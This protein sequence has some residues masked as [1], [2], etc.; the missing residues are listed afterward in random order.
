MSFSGGG[1]KIGRAF[2]ASM[3]LTSLAAAQGLRI[4]STSIGTM[5]SGPYLNQPSL[6]IVVSGQ[7]SLANGVYPYSLS[8]RIVWNDAP[9]SPLYYSVNAFISFAQGRDEL[10]QIPLR[11]I[12][13]PNG[14]FPANSR[15]TLTMTIQ[16]KSAVSWFT[17]NPALNVRVVS[18]PPD[19]VPTSKRLRKDY[20]I[21]QPSTQSYNFLIQVTDPV[22]GEGVANKIVKFQISR[23]MADSGH[24]SHSLPLNSWLHELTGARAD[25]SGLSLES[26]TVIGQYDKGGSS[27]ASREIITASGGYAALR[28][29]PFEFSGFEQIQAVVD[30]QT[31]AWHDWQVRELTGLVA[32]PNSSQY[33][34]FTNSTLHPLGTSHYS[35]PGNKAR[36]ENFASYF[37]NAQLN[38]YELITLRNELTGLGY[39]FG[40]QRPSQIRPAGNPR[41]VEINDISLIYGGMFD[42]SGNGAPPHGGHREG[43]NIDV[44]TKYFIRDAYLS[45]RVDSDATEIE[46]PFTWG[47][48]DDYQDIPFDVFL[49]TE[50]YNRR[51]AELLYKS[52]RQAGLRIIAE[53]DHWHTTSPD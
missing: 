26:D 19:L 13:P 29:T 11:L 9:G 16:S 1:R 49:K 8:T 24:Q 33:T 23:N 37:W 47:V 28:I 30:K 41:P 3:L 25:D 34:K 5:A 6:N 48:P 31:V 42:I 50:A 46:I 18:R 45:Y 20:A 38:D 53:G 21:K 51:L 40:T 39:V 35:T 32:L 17:I 7:S 44:R 4:S 36:I 15:G 12:Y 2:F 43:R 14:Q 52:I 22:S 10:V 27:V